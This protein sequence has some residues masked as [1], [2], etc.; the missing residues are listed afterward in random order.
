MTSSSWVRSLDRMRALEPEVLVPSHTRPIVGKQAVLQALTED[1]DAIQ[2][3]HDQTV[4]GM[5]QGLSPDQLVERVRLPARLAESPHLQPY[6]GTVGW[7]V[8]GILAGYL[9]WFDG[10]PTHLAPTFA[11]ERAKQWQALL[12]EGCTLRAASEDAMKRADWQWSAELLELH[13][14]QLVRFLGLFQRP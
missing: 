14:A 1:R 8:R 11:L 9:G 4:R 5:N 7:S 12:P 10:D 13:L 2:F 6:Y 3:V